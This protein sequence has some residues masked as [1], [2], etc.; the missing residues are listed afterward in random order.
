MDTELDLGMLIIRLALGPMLIAHG[1]N[2]VF[3]GGGLAGTT[4]WF[5]GLG[6]KPAWLHARLAPVNEIGAGILLTLGLATPLAAAAFV[7]LMTVASLTDHRG[8][9]YFVFKGGWEYTLLVGIVAVGV[10][11]IGP[12]DWSLDHLL[13]WEWYGVGWAVF[14]A[15]LGVGAALLLLAVS[16]RPA[17]KTEE[18][19]A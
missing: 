1:Y 19:N 3:G 5:D 15:V 18:A 11:A 4:R 16:Y 10:A 14:A 17:P 8:K 13:G 7:G 2:K 9:G 12:G 6:L